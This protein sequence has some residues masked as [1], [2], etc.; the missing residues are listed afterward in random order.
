MT[1]TQKQLDYINSMIDGIESAPYFAGLEVTI[2]ELRQN[3]GSEVKIQM[4]E[5]Q[6]SLWYAELLNIRL[7]RNPITLS[8]LKAQAFEAIHNLRAM[9]ARGLTSVEASKLIDDLKNKKLV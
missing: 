3:G 8:T 5:G 1:A 9:V 7:R 2:E 4:L 6:V